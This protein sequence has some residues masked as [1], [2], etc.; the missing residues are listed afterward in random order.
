MSKVLFKLPIC[1]KQITSETRWINSTKPRVCEMTDEHIE[2]CRMWLHGNIAAEKALYG[3][4]KERGGFTYPEWAVIFKKEEER[5]RTLKL[6]AINL[7]KTVLQQELKQLDKM[8]AATGQ[9]VPKPCT[10]NH[11]D[12][13]DHAFAAH[14]YMLNAYGY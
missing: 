3:C 9:Y 7:A 4:H 5:R 1:N 10:N 14:E 12:T 13:D 2:N 8:A 6:E 11:D